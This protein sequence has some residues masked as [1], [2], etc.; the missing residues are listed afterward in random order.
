MNLRSLR[1]R[2]ARRMIDGTIRTMMRINPDAGSRVVNRVARSYSDYV[3]ERLS[4]ASRG[5]VPSH[6]NPDHLSDALDRSDISQIR[7]ALR[8]IVKAAPIA[9]VR[10]KI[11]P[12]N[13]GDGFQVDNYILSQFIVEE[14]V[15]L[16]DH[17]PYP[18]PELHLMVAAVC[19]VQP[20]LIIEWGTNV[21]GSARIFWYTAKKFDIPCHI[22]SIDLPEGAYHS[23]NIAT[24]RAVHVRG[25]PDISLHYGDGLDIGL[26]I[27][28]DNPG[29]RCLFFLDGDHAYESV[30]RELEGI[31]GTSPKTPILM[32]DTHPSWHRGPREALH[33]ALKTRPGVYRTASTEIGLPG[34]TFVYP[35]S[36]VCP[37]SELGKST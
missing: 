35:N 29:A 14:L 24:N 4:G 20:H 7:N 3:A 30:R 16:V 19:W 36:F 31:M 34:M 28:C 27:L 5:G 22:H 12:K 10:E 26:K 25:L 1:N 33:D 15:H 9:V 11:M 6:P 37:D 17:W 2:A 23:E 21:G 8:T 32:H 18:P 13:Q